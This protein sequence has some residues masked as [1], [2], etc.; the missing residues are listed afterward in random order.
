MLLLFTCCVYYTMYV[1]ICQLV[2]AHILAVAIGLCGGFEMPEKSSISESRRKA[3]QKY[4]SKFVELKIRISPEY[5]DEI[6]RH[7]ESTGESTAAFMR[8]AI[9]ETMERD[10][11]QNT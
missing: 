1:P 4:L 11:S 8:R 10:R 3:T 5:R 9:A 6:Q 2:C 7:A